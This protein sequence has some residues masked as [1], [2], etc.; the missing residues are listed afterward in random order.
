MTCRHCGTEIAD[1]ALVCFRCGAATAEPAAAPPSARR[2]SSIGPKVA[3]YAF[4]LLV[5]L[6]LFVVYEGPAPN[7]PSES[8]RWAILAGVAAI[9]VFRVIARRR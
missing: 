6:I 3:L 9:V 1:K 4:V 5:L 8:V 7:L 2:R